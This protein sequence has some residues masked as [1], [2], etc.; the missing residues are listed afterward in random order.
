MVSLD[1]FNHL[2]EELN[3]NGTPMAVVNIYSTYPDY[4]Y[5][6]EPNEGF[7]CV[8]DVAR[9]IVM[10]VDYLKV[11]EGKGVRLQLR[12]LIE[13]VLFMQNENGYFNNFI[14]PDLSVNTDYRTSRAEMGWWSFRALWSLQYA[15]T[16]I[17]GDDLLAERIDAASDRLVDNLKRDLFANKFETKTVSTLELPT[18]LPH[19]FAADQAAVAIVGLLLYQQR[20]HD[21]VVLALVRS[22][23][24]G[25]MKMQKGTKDSYP[26][27]MFL[28]WKNTWHA[29]GNSQAYALLLAGEALKRNDYLAS[30]LLEIDHFYPYLLEQGFAASIQIQ[31]VDGVVRELSKTKFPQIAYGIRPMVFAAIEA[32]RITGDRK[33]LRLASDLK[34]WFLGNN[35]AGSAMYNASN[36]LIFDGIIDESNINL[37]SGAESTIEGLLVFLR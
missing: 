37:D 29:W 34:A 22:L 35:P 2:Y 14:W 27:G 17:K 16:A 26:F 7:A 6:I 9:A 19:E 10:L 32:N 4:E 24:D 1:H 18:W 8:D 5:S 21:D 28:S 11:K 3:I 36:G 30:A 25:I 20:K 33:Y 13:F 31:E 12:K 23:A 15:Y